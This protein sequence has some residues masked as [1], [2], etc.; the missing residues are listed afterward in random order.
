MFASGFI[1]G[2]TPCAQIFSS[3]FFLAYGK[4][5]TLPIAQLNLL[6]D[7][8]EFSAVM[9]IIFL[10][11]LLLHLSLFL[12]WFPHLLIIYNLRI[13]ESNRA[14]LMWVLGKKGDEGE[15]PVDRKFR[16]E[17]CYFKHNGLW[18]REQG[19]GGMER[20]ISSC[21]SAWISSS[22]SGVLLDR[23]KGKQK[24]PEHSQFL[25]RTLAMVL[26]WGN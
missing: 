8:F 11:V 1:Y 9:G 24:N 20:R 23:L 14:N 22:R 17:A 2:I 4:F 26:Y 19:Y 10:V 6:L 25:F 21:G 5:L 16:Q 15:I 12:N 7:I 3:Q 13:C 18:K